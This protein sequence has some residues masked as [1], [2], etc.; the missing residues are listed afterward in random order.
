MKTLFKSPSGDLGAKESEEAYIPGTCNIGKVEIR[1]R[2]RIGYTGLTIAI[3]MGVIIE[4]TEAHPYWKFLVVIPVFYSVSGFIQAWK[5]FCYLYGFMQVFSL[6][7]RRTFTKVRD[8]SYVKEDRKTAIQIVS[9]V[10]LVSL[11]ITFAYYF[12]SF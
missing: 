11:M 9:L 3:I 6:N 2:Y 8:E 5:K 12:L 1:R 4:L 7:G 10:F